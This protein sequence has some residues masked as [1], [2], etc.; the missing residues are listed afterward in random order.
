[1]RSVAPAV[2]RTPLLDTG[3]AELLRCAIVLIT[4]EPIGCCAMPTASARTFGSHIDV[5]STASG[6]AHLSNA[7]SDVTL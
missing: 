7:M 1:M 2:P 4:M 6:R 3:D 5:V